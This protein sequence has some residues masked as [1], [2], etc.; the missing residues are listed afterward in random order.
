M[1]GKKIRFYSIKII[2]A[3][4]AIAVGFL[5]YQKQQTA[6]FEEKSLLQ[7]ILSPTPADIEKFLN[8]DIN[9]GET[10]LSKKE[11]DFD[12]DGVKEWMFV[13]FYNMSE[14]YG[15]PR[16]YD[17]SARVGILKFDFQKKEWELVFEDITESVYES[18]GGEGIVET[19]EITDLNQDKKDELIVSIRIGGSGGFRDWFIVADFDGKTQIAKQNLPG[20]FYD[21]RGFG[22]HNTVSIADGLIKEKFLIYLPGDSNCCPQGGIKYLY[23]RFNGSQ[24]VL[25]KEELS[26]KSDL[27]Q[28]E[29][30]RPGDE[31]SSPLKIYGQAKGYWFFEASFPVVLVDWDGRIIAQGIATAQDEWMTK[32]F[33]SFTTELT[34]EKPAFIGDFS[35]RGALILRKDNPSGLPEHDDALEIPIMF[36]Q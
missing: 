36:K 19:F 27:I 33:V 8:I 26:P 16:P 20:E 29:S 12:G 1:I 30:P 9:I 35:K 13:S 21:Q 24:L 7:S 17:L 10:L 32:N 5:I 2:I 23:F 28:V 34:F 11:A 4:T 18:P 6:P 25:E 22:G 15:E 3:I 14:F 31:I